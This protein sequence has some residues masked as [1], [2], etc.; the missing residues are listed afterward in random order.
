MAQRVEVGKRGVPADVGSGVDV[1]RSN[2]KAELGIETG[3]IA[4]EGVSGIRRGVENG[5]MKRRQL[6]PRR[7]MD[8][9]PGIYLTEE[10]LDLG[11]APTGARGAIGDSPGVVIGAVPPHGRAAVM[12]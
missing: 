8:P 9:Q 10:R 5:A 1:D 7:G 4:D 11:R 2:G 12:G 6:L 3:E